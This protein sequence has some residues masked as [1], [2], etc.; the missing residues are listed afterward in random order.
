MRNTDI[1]EAIKY[2][3]QELLRGDLTDEERQELNVTI[4]N[5]YGSLQMED[6]LLLVP[7]DRI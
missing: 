7:P 2:L 4:G 3:E 1:E 5:L 6:D